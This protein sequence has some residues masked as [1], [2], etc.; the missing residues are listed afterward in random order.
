MA[1]RNFRTLLENQ[2]EHNKFL[3]VGLDSDIGK[4][5]DVIRQPGVGE[6][7]VAFNKAIIDATKDVVCAYKPNSAYYEA[8]GDMGW[9]A[10]EETVEYIRSEAPEVPVIIDA[11]RGDIGNTNNGYVEAFFERMEADAITVHPYMGSESLA[12]LLERKD[13]G[14]IVL[15]RTS[16]PGAGEFQD[17]EI[18][19]EHLY[20]LVARHVASEWNTNG[21]C[22]IVVG[23]TYPDELRNVREI[24]GDMP[25][26]IPGIGAQG[27]DLEKTVAAGKDERGKGMMIAVSRSVIFASGGADF[28]GAA[29]AKAEELDAVI[30]KT[31]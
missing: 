14:V 7:L 25:I 1:E 6:T 27:G 23:A 10:L 29:R 26:L 15:C 30:R 20:K 22:S 11:K 13:K 19:G 28:A 12:P 24:V 8:H 3:C 5:P 9:A 31:L 16:N 2:W 17:L 21:N 18:G 4:I